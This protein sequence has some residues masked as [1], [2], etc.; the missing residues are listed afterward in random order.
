[1]KLFT[2]KECSNLLYFENTHCERCG[3]LLGFLPDDMDLHTLLPRQVQTFSLKDA[4]PEHYRY[5]ANAQLQACNWLLPA[6][7]EDPLCQACSLNHTIPNLQ[8][9]GHV[10]L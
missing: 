8:E 2:C 7:Q 9:A 1:M 5:C 3:S 4:G 10:V 6:H